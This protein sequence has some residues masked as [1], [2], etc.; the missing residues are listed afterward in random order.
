MRFILGFLISLTTA[1]AAFAGSPYIAIGGEVGNTETQTPTG[2]YTATAINGRVGYDFGS[3]FGVEAEG[4]LH[5]G[6]SATLT[7]QVDRITREF[8]RDVTSRYGVFLRGRVPVSDRV[9]LFGRAGFGA[10]Y[11][12]YTFGSFGIYEFDGSTFDETSSRDDTN[13]YGA[14]GIGA[15]FQISDDERNTIRTDLTRYRTYIGG[16][17]QDEDYATDTVFSLAYVRRF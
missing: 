2:S 16:E 12:T 7:D 9:S 11:E 3:Y 5:V 17:D 1:G 15:E 6:G 13:I 4:A 10:R 14:L 8:E